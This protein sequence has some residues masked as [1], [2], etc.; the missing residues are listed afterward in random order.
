MTNFK[1]IVKHLSE[2]DNQLNIIHRNTKRDVMC[3]IINCIF[4]NINDAILLDKVKKVKNKTNV[5]N[6]VLKTMNHK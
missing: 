1:F 2:L 6:S 5:Q 3:K 4:G